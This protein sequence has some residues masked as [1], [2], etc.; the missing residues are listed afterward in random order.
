MS[1]TK[2]DA[3]SFEDRIRVDSL[4]GAET[5]RGLVQISFGET[6]VCLTPDE[7]RDVARNLFA[8]AEAA[9][10][11]EIM[12]AF[13]ERVSKGTLALQE[14]AMAL[15][16]LRGLRSQMCSKGEEAA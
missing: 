3:K 9:E 7:A 15:R 14:K 4:F 6:S 12:L 1:D 2:S 8:C 10:S 13:L 16:E 11:D 5:Q